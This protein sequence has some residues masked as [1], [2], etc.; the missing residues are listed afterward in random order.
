MISV[1][2][3][4]FPQGFDSANFQNAYLFTQLFYNRYMDKYV[5]SSVRWS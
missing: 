5:L 2:G 4:V 1:N 3:G